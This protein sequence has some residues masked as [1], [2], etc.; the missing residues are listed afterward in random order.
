MDCSMLEPYEYLPEDLGKGD[1][2]T[3]VL[4]N[5]EKA[6]ANLIAKEACILA[7]VE[8][9]TRIFEHQGLLLRHF[10]SDG[11]SVRPG[12]IIMEISG[13][14]KGILKAERLALNFIMRMSG[15]ATLTRR[16]VEKC[17]SI[18]PDVKIAA[19]RKTTPGFRKYEKK[20]VELGGGI[21]HREGLYDHILIKDNHLRFVESITDAIQRARKSGL[22]KI[23]EIEVADLPGAIEAAKA[24]ADIIMLDNMQPDMV[25]EAG[26]SIRDINQRIEIEIS[27]GVTPDNITTYAEFADRISLGW[28]THS[29]KACDFSVEIVEVLTESQDE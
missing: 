10:C 11:D 4:I 17:K 14:A 28:L 7:G 12:T 23:V 13:G 6:R 9:A 8:E 1:V 19:T 26:R 18:N 22:S 5:D 15:I 20:A 2:T 24:G 29:V 25:K 16:L 3:E 21:R 27:G